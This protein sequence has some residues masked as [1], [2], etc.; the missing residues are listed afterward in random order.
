MAGQGSDAGTG[1][2]PTCTLT[3]S[4]PVE[5]TADGQVIEGLRIT[6]P[7]GPGI[8]IQGYKGVVVRNVEV[9]HADGVG[10]QVNDAPDAI[11]EHVAITFTAA[12][13]SGGNA[14]AGFLNISCHQSP[15]LVVAHARLTRGS[16]GIY[17]QDCDGSLLQHIEGHDFRGPFPRGQLVQWNSS[18]DGVLEDFSVENPPGSW[19]ED[20]VNVYKSSNAIVRR[21]L[22]DGNNSPSGVGVIFDGDTS[23]GLVEDVDA[24]RMGN[25]CF[26]NYAGA[27]GNVFRRTRCR[28]NIC[29]DQGRGLPK[30]N[31]LM[32][33]GRP[34]LSALRIEDS[35]WFAACNP[36]NI[37]WPKN[38]F[39]VI[40]VQE[41]DFTLRPP[42][43]IQLCWE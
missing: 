22:V 35:T 12:P 10:I 20:N 19:P 33:A 6:A 38:S 9:L 36:G 41:A 8:R 11:I 34:G 32:W 13:P 17:L 28:D 14:S 31:A 40:E 15:G 16:S 42:E 18:D 27:D 25:G 26:S 5:A 43:R 37:V 29:E 21:G 1:G 4:G 24:V 3:D 23:T 2:G 7:S 30:S 39:A